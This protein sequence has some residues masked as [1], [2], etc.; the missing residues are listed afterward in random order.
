MG[1]V[2]EVEDTGPGIAPEVADRIFDPFFTTREKG[3][4]LGLSV[5]HRIIEANQGR[6]QLTTGA[7]GGALFRIRL[8]SA[9]A[10]V[11]VEA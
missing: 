8:V 7:G 2:L 6:I 3:S 10:A 5:V 4:G 11:L 1:V 9:T